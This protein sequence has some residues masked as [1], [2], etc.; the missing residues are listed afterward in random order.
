[1][2]KG[3]KKRNDGGTKV[4]GIS[5]TKEFW[6]EVEAQMAETGM[7]RSAVV[8]ETCIF[9]WKVSILPAKSVGRPKKKA[10]KVCGK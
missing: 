3:I 1:M 9:N 7:S 4:F 8:V 5:A 10:K 6:D 2:S